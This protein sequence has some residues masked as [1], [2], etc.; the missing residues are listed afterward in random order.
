MGN[1][2]VAFVDTKHQL[3]DMP[4]KGLGMKTFKLL[5][6]AAGIKEKVTVI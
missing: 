3:A 6:E 1:A 4:I 2:K 5:R